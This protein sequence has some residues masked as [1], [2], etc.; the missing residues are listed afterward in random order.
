MMN[1]SD[2]IGLGCFLAAITL[3]LGQ[4]APPPEGVIET[5]LRICSDALAISGGFLLIFRKE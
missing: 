5:A 4:I 2:R 3:L 1:K